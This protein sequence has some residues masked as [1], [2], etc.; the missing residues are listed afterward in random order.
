[1]DKGSAHGH[2]RRHPPPPK[3][4]DRSRHPARNGHQGERR[5]SGRRHQTVIHDEDDEYV[6]WPAFRRPNGEV[7]VEDYGQWPHELSDRSNERSTYDPRVTVDEPVQ[8]PANNV[9]KHRRDENGR[10]TDHRSRKSPPSLE[11]QPAVRH[12]PREPGRR[13]TGEEKDEAY[14]DDDDDLGDSHDDD[15]ELRPPPLRSIPQ[16][17]QSSDSLARQPAT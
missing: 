6:N 17:K 2:R 7:G 1:S 5:S 9:P 11:P 4:S 13:G 10:R 3:A 15:E 12:Y 8:P 16:S 14:E